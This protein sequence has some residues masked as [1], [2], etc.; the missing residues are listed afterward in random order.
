MLSNVFGVKKEASQ[1]DYSGGALPTVQGVPVPSP[2]TNQSSPIQN[3]NNADFFLLLGRQPA[4]MAQC[5]KCNAKNTRTFVRT[6]PSLISWFLGIGFFVLCWPLYYV[7]MYLIPFAFLPLIYDKVRVQI[8][9]C[10]Y[11][12]YVLVTIF[13]SSVIDILIVQL[14]RSDHYC[15]KCNRQVGSIAPLS[16]CG[17]KTLS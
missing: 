6:Y 15:S 5:P 8:Q 1:H 11:I 12:F 17:V 2:A 3:N 16:D 7:P 9:Q 13:A 14:K 10:K 4:M